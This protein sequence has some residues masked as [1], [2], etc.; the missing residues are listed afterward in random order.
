MTLVD[1]WLEDLRREEEIAAIV[2]ARSAAGSTAALSEVAQRLGI[3]LDEEWHVKPPTPSCVNAAHANKAVNQIHL[4]PA[5][6]GL[7]VSE[8]RSE[9]GDRIHK[10]I[11]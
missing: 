5:A 10:Q 3:S 1:A 7:T 9:S 11:G 8:P 2:H 6:T 4:H